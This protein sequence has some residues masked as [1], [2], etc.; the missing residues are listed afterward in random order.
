MM[1]NVAPYSATAGDVVNVILAIIIG[2]FSLATLGPEMQG[3]S[4]I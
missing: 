3:T 1:S 4:L 2:S